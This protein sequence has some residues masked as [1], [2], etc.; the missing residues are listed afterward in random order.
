MLRLDDVSSGF[1]HQVVFGLEGLLARHGSS[2]SWRLRTTL[3]RVG[4][5]HCLK[6][7][8]Q[9]P[10]LRDER[11]IADSGRK[12]VRQN[13]DETTFRSVGNLLDL[14][15]QDGRITRLERHPVDL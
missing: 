7:R 6:R 5:L 14:L 9:P 13:L 15:E 4:H 8:L 2:S 10:S 12:L 1:A 11:R 3:R